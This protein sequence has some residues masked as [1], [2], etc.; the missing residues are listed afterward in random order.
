MANKIKG[1]TVV[2]DKDYSSEYAE[3]IKNA[4]EMLR[5]VA[6]VETSVASS[7]D[8]IVETRTKIKIS[9]DLIEFL[10]TKLK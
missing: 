3:E 4:I 1:F 7:D 6:H 5:G 9:E 2:L 10:Q 8:Y